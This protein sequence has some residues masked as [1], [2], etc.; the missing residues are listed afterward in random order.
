MIAQE[1]HDR[2]SARFAEILKQ[3]LQVGGNVPA[4]RRGV[5][6]FT[7]SG[8]RTWDEYVG[9]SRAKGQLRASICSATKRESRLDHVLIAAGQYGA[10]KTTLAR[11][12]AAEMGVGIVELSGKISAEQVRPILRGMQPRDIL[13]IDEIHLMVAGGKSGAEWILHLLEDGR[14]LSAAGAEPMPDI[15][16]IAAT[17]D[18]GKLPETILS[19]FP[20]RPTLDGATLPE[21]ST[22]ALG[23]AERL[24]FGTDIPALTPTTAVLV[25][26]AANRNGRDMRSLLVTLRDAAYGGMAPTNEAGDYDL[27]HPLEWA[28][29][30]FDGLSK[31]AQDYLTVLLM[32]FDGKA[33]ERTIAAALG[34]PGPLHHVEKLLLQKGFLAITPSGRALT[35]RGT[36]RSGNLLS[37]DQS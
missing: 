35:E 12:I 2:M 30:S 6:I 1:Q 4:P 10:G 29:L 16:V 20:I 3:G 34:E 33:G 26:E 9:Q 21:A 11:L 18:A 17:T 22:I 8:P 31:Q 24:G 23:M 14:I 15:T 5:A 7:G 32:D 36:A 37:Q 13:F 19:R 25:A 28:G 27:K